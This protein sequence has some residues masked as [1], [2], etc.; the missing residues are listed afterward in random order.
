M[1]ARHIVV[2]VVV[3]ALFAA[4][5]TSGAA[6]SASTRAAL[7]ASPS[8]KDNQWPAGGRFVDAGADTSNLASDIYSNGLPPELE[9]RV[10]VFQRVAAGG[11]QAELDFPAPVVQ[12]HHYLAGDSNDAGDAFP[13]EG[14]PVRHTVALVL[15]PPRGSPTTVSVQADGSTVVTKGSAQIA[16]ATS[17]FVGNRLIIA[18]PEVA[19][20][21]TDWSVQ[22]VIRIAGDRPLRPAG[23]QRG[24]PAE[25]VY[26]TQPAIVGVLT[27]DYAGRPEPLLGKAILIGTTPGVQSPDPVDVPAGGRPTSLRLERNGKSAV[28]VV[29]VDTPPRAPRSSTKVN[30]QSVQ[31]ETLRLS[32][33]PDVQD[34]LGFARIDVEYFY[35]TSTCGQ[36]KCPA[37][38][39][40]SVVIAGNDLGTVPVT[41]SGKEVRFD[42]GRFT[43]LKQS[44]KPNSS[45]TTGEQFIGTTKDTYTLDAQ[46]LD[47]VPLGPDTPPWSGQTTIALDGTSINITSPAGETAKGVVNPFTG[48]FFATDADEMWSGFLGKQGWYERIRS[49]VRKTAA[50]VGGAPTDLESDSDTI[51]EIASYYWTQ[52]RTQGENTL[53]RDLQAIVS[54]TRLFGGYETNPDA[55]EKFRAAVEDWLDDYAPQELWLFPIGIDPVVVPTPAP[56]PF[57]FAKRFPNLARKNG[58]WEI[59]AGIQITGAQGS[60]VFTYGPYVPASS[61]IGSRKGP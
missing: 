27:G 7:T 17:V 4:G 30:G 33:A 50:L 26:A 38:T 18:V 8:T 59:A 28:A 34:G 46:D 32:I 5:S 6:T 11:W 16:T 55:F 43:P 40:A 23:G 12:L 56:I 25:L 14:I 53:P 49:Q 24:L 42:L 13:D 57:P 2:G 19:K 45:N 54:S 37:G 47:M 61:L 22:A 3:G 52:K 15:Q 39:L 51:Q 36:P 1:N 20:V 44:T 58:Q 48:Y 9:P 29:T 21:G 60:L 35:P 41:L 31:Q 10:F